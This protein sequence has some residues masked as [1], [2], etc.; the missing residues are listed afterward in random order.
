MKQP[1]NFLCIPLCTNFEKIYDEKYSIDN[2]RYWFSFPCIIRPAKLRLWIHTDHSALDTLLLHCI[3]CLYFMNCC[4][5][6]CPVSFQTHAV[7][8]YVMVQVERWPAGVWAMEMRTNVQIY[9]TRKY[10]L[11]CQKNILKVGD[12]DWVNR[13]YVRYW[14]IEFSFEALHMTRAHIRNSCCTKF[15]IQYAQ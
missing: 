7:P 11:G 9:R 8:G 10:I 3:S 1:D 2:S 5:C 13:W 4:R 15:S 6:T 14:H 12:D